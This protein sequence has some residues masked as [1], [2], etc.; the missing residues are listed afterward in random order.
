[1]NEDKTSPMCKSKR[2]DDKK[3]CKDCGF[4]GLCLSH[5]ENQ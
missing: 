5:E 4:T 3:R 2:Y 1:M